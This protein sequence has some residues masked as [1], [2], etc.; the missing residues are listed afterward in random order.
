MILGYSLQLATRSLRRNIVL[1][2]LMIAAVGVG[3]GASMT[4]LT[5]L[6][7]MSSDPI[8]DKSS[9]LFV[10]Q[11]DVD[12]YA[13]EHHDSRNLPW[14]L[15]YRDAMVF[16]KGRFGARQAVMYPLGL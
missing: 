14:N 6:L 9:Q 13:T 7:V 16:M 3:I 1:T 4:M 2:A 10:P 12:G 8:P 15:T 11:F 5:T